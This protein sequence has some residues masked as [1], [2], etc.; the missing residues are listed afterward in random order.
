MVADFTMVSIFGA[1]QTGL[2]VGWFLAAA[3][4]VLAV[5]QILSKG[6]AGTVLVASAVIVAVGLIGCR[7]WELQSGGRY[8]LLPGSD[9]YAYVGFSVSVMCWCY[10]RNFPALRALGVSAGAALL[11][12]SDSVAAIVFGATAVLIAIVM[13]RCGRVFIETL[14][15][16]LAVVAVFLAAI[17]AFPILLMEG[18]P[19]DSLPPSGQSRVII[20]RMMLA[21]VADRTWVD[22]MFGSGWGS[23]YFAFYDHLL[24]AP[25]PIYDR[26]WDFIWRDMF[27][28]HNGFLEIFWTI[29]A[30]GLAVYT[31]MLALCANWLLARRNAPLVALFVFYVAMS[32]VW[33]EFSFCLPFLI[34]A[35]LTCLEYPS[36]CAEGGARGAFGS[37]R[38]WTAMAGTAGAVCLFLFAFLTPFELAIRSYK[39]DRA[40]LGDDLGTFF[41]QFPSDPRGSRHVEAYMLNRL[42]LQ[43]A[44]LANGLVARSHSE[45]TEIQLAEAILRRTAGLS[46]TTR[47]PHIMQ[48][49]IN[50][51][52]AM[53]K[54][55]GPEGQAWALSRIDMWRT[56]I[57]RH[58]ELSPGRFDVTILY[59]EALANRRDGDALRRWTQE[60]IDAVQGRDPVALYFNALSWLILNPNIDNTPA[61]RR[62]HNAIQADLNRAIPVSPE[63][64]AQLNQR[65][66]GAN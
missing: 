44:R 49:G 39:V 33:F 17:F 56:L 43:R 23:V 35:A 60:R 59:N 1:F 25:S 10:S 7:V 19:F 63:F 64:A 8:I 66:G 38:L 27:H 62:I 14:A 42:W 18:V 41:A 47:T 5:A 34:L 40:N 15:T 11:L 6:S 26:R 9:S 28:S 58:F 31:T 2:G 51:L 16:R 61:L 30:L 37:Q 55:G 45:I 36:D 29:G 3:L 22:V 13:A 53:Y 20:W 12:V 52:G 24:N 46:E 4:T 50:I 65:F 48:L 21:S 32:T 54:N 57:E